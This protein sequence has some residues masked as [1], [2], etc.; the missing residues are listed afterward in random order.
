MPEGGLGTLHEERRIPTDLRPCSRAWEHGLSVCHLPHAGLRETGDLVSG[1][2]KM[3]DGTVA[4]SCLRPGCMRGWTEAERPQ[5]E[6]GI[7]ALVGTLGGPRRGEQF[8]DF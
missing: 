5:Q 7:L 6:A 1:R 8:L 4:R 3:A 2:V